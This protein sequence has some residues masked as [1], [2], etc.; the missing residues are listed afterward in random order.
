[1][2]QTGVLAGHDPHVKLLWN[3]SVCLKLTHDL[4][5]LI[6]PFDAV[7]LRPGAHAE[8][9]GGGCTLTALSD[10]QTNQSMSGPALVHYPAGRSEARPDDRRPTDRRTDG[11][12][13]GSMTRDQPDEGRRSEMDPVSAEKHTLC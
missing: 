2:N 11:C 13:A 6:V 5:F 9:R 1:M 7:A 3:A 4:F 8:R 12:Q 10:S